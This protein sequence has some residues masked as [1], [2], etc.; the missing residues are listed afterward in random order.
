M[1]R[2]TGICFSR[3]LLQATHA[4]YDLI[5]ILLIFVPVFVYVDDGLRKYRSISTSSITRWRRC[6]SLPQS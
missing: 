1:I 3:K 2:L 5:L 4:S 6:P